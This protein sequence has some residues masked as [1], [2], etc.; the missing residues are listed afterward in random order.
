MKA[1]YATVLNCYVR[2]IDKFLS[3]LA[4]KDNFVFFGEQNSNVAVVI[5]FYME[6]NMKLIADMPSF[7]KPKCW[8]HV[9]KMCLLH[10][11]QTQIL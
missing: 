4:L 3:F 7:R 1:R 6:I 8:P 9:E 2:R 11:M 5:K 10:C